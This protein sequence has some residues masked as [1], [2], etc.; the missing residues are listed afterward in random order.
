[1]FILTLLFG[2]FILYGK[3]KYFPENLPSIETPIKEHKNLAT[4]AG[5]FLL[6]L[7]FLLFQDKFGT[8]TA[9]VLYTLSIGLIYCLL[10]TVLTIHNKYV[11][12][13]A[14]L[15]ILSIIFESLL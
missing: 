14:A 1:M 8:G 4:L 3:S 11:Y 12:F 7:S 15:S 5:Y 6:F 13:I 10:I 2:C 9:I